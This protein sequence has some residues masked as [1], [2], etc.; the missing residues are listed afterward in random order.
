MFLDKWELKRES[1]LGQKQT[2]FLTPNNDR[3]RV[4]S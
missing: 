2:L 1:G 3:F 4:Q